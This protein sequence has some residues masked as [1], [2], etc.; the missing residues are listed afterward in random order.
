[1][2]DGLLSVQH[3]KPDDTPDQKVKKKK[4]VSYRYSVKGKQYIP[5]KVR[6]VRCV[7]PLICSG[8]PCFPK[9][10]NSGLTLWYWYYT[11]Y[12]FV[13]RTSWFLP[14]RLLLD[15]NLTFS[16]WKCSLKRPK[17][18]SI[19][20]ED[21]LKNCRNW[22]TCVSK[23]LPTF[24]TNLPLPCQNFHNKVIFESEFGFCSA[25]DICN[26]GILTVSRLLFGLSRP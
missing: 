19:L 7:K 14:S 4:K 5:N 9:L 8:S 18:V 6:A 12:I 21:Y 15:R 11:W 10:L 1:M 25:C 26:I 16:Q 2:A 13:F 17:E 20:G 3:R 22:R 23:N 24:H